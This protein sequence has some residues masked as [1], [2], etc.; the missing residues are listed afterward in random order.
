MTEVIAFQNSDH[1]PFG[2]LFSLFLLEHIIPPKFIIF[3]VPSV[4]CTLFSVFKKKMLFLITN[5][6]C[7]FVRY[8][9][10]F[11]NWSDLKVSFQSLHL[12]GNIDHTF[13]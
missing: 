7:C 6:D 10:L 2:S 11:L 13:F 12:G 8:F 4:L 9:F 5:S 1:M 3:S